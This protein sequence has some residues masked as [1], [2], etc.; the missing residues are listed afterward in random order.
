MNDVPFDYYSVDDYLIQLQ[1]CASK[2][3]TMSPPDLASA[4]WYTEDGETYEFSD[5]GSSAML[6]NS[7]GETEATIMVEDYGDGILLL[8]FST[9]DGTQVLGTELISFSEMNDFEG[10]TVYSTRVLWEFYDF[11]VSDG[12]LSDTMNKDGELFI[13]EFSSSIDFNWAGWHGNTP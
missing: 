4:V 2:S 8:T 10:K 12:S 11:P 5:D 13:G 7:A 1:D 9:T 3:L 6:K